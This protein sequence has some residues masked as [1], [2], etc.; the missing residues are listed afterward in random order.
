MLSFKQIT[1]IRL[2]NFISYY[3]FNQKWKSLETS[4]LLMTSPL[5]EPIGI[6][7]AA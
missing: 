7:H 5:T 6:V 3:A 4:D 2:S 1:D